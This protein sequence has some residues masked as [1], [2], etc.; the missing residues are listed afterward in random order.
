MDTIPSEEAPRYGDTVFGHIMM[1]KVI[2]VHLVSELGYDI[3]FQDVDVIWFKDPLKF[4]HNPKSAIANFD[5]Y[6]QGK[7]IGS[8]IVHLQVADGIFL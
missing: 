6:F 3:L 2:C 4:F 7:D 8:Y 1:A 5:V